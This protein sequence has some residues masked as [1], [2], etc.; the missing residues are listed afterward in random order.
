MG[1]GGNRALVAGF[2]NDWLVVSR[3]SPDRLDLSI[4]SCELQASTCS[5]RDVVSPSFSQ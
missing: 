2:E 4:K 3:K 5:C 1:D